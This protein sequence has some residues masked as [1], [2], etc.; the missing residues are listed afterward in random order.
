MANPAILTSR[1]IAAAFPRRAEVL[2]EAKAARAAASAAA[3]KAQALEELATKLEWTSEVIE[4]MPVHLESSDPAQRY[5]LSTVG[6]PFRLAQAYLSVRAGEG[7]RLNLSDHQHFA[8]GNGT[9]SV[10]GA[11][12]RDEAIAMARLFVAKGIVPSGAEKG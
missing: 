4:G 9:Y 12:S 1:S 11:W 7:W 2:R 8:S 6:E 3:I 10:P 5:Q